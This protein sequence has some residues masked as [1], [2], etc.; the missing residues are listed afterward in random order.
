MEKLSCDNNEETILKRF[1]A[2]NAVYRYNCISNNQHKL[3]RSLE[4]RKIDYDKQKVAKANKGSKRSD[5]EEAPP[6][7]LADYRYLFCG[8]SNDVSKLCAGGTQHE[9][10][11]NINEEKN[12]AFSDNLWR[13]ASKFQ[14]SCV[15][16]ILSLG[17]VMIQEMNYHCVCLTEFHNRY[18]ALV[19]SETK[20]QP[21]DSYK[22]E[23]H[24]RKI[25]LHV[26]DQ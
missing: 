9:T 13:Q 26:L 25:V 18:R 2:N 5:I 11:K 22:T 6:I 15:L 14:D 1:K 17:S 8:V 12:R 4:K 3:K 21:F 19:I 16:S 23:L 24:F 10:L 7:I 20:E